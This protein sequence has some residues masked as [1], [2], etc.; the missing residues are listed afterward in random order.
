M[1]K[2]Y[3]DEQAAKVKSLTDK[4]GIVLTEEESKLIQ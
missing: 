4:Y 2:A 3:R 1:A